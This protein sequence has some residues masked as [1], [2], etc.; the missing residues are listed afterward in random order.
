[1][2]DAAGAVGARPRIFYGWVVVAAAFAVMFLGFGVAYSFGAFFKALQTEFAATRAEISLIFSVSSALYFALGALSG[3][4]ADRF[5]PRWL[6]AAG[7]VLI[8]LGLLVASRAG[9]LWQV[10]VTYGLAVG[11]GVGLSYVPAVAAVQPWFTRRRGL[12]SGLAVAGIGVGT[13]VMPFVATWLIGLWDWRGTYLVMAALAIVFG[14]AASLLL[15]NNPA[16]RGLAAEGEPPPTHASAGPVGAAPKAVPGVPLRDALRSRPF[17]LYYAASL[18]TSFGLFIPFVHLPS[19]ATDRGMSEATGV[20]LLG[21]FG[22]GSIVGRFALGGA[23]DRY[24]RKTALTGLFVAMAALLV[25]WHL[26]G[27]FWGLAVFAVV[28]G[29]CYGGFVALSP[30]LMMDFYGARKVSSIL[31]ILY[32]AP[33]F[34][35][36]LGPTLAGLAYDV[37]RSYALPILGAAAAN[38]LAALCLALVPQPAK[39]REG[40]T[41]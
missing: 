26:T 41:G 35:V 1:M 13:F 29:S 3:P 30:A 20:L 11:V 8:A 15:E 34:S 33:S 2:N 4:L 12:A 22:V 40:R 37:S 9:S 28:F 39:W 17:I 14:V 19:Y 7:M 23:A 24:G 27:S 36:L 25:W 21:L 32:T 18:M 16:R 10:Y 5:G 6:S 38:L 31:G